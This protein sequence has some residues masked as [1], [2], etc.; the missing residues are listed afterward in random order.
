MEQQPTNPNPTDRH[1]RPA[2]RIARPTARSRVTNGQDLLPGV[3]GRTLLARRYR[4]ILAQL[5]ADQG[6]DLSEARLQLCRR[7]A[8]AACIAEGMEAKLARGESIDIAE[9]AQLSSTLVRLAQRIGI[10][11]VPRD[12]TPSVADY[13]AS[14]ARGS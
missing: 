14:L 10:D 9:H 3:D 11:R 8:A 6:N 2:T 1:P 13:V 7:F 4:D 12:V 5:V